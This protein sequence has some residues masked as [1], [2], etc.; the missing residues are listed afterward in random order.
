MGNKLNR[1]EH[2]THHTQRGRRRRRCRF[3]QKTKEKASWERTET[4]TERRTIAAL[5]AAFLLALPSP[6]P[7]REI[8]WSELFDAPVVVTRVH[9]EEVFEPGNVRVRVTASGTEHGGRTGALHHLELRAHIYGGETWGQLIL[10]NT[11]TPAQLNTHADAHAHAHRSRW[12]NLKKDARSR[13]RSPHRFI[14][15]SVHTAA[16]NN[17]HPT[18]TYSWTVFVWPCHFSINTHIKCSQ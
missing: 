5:V 14:A 10:W 3:L 6:T 2:K 8:T 1:Q 15:V 7:G 11:G 18:F 9:R 12:G 13:P 16:I 17:N 4:Q